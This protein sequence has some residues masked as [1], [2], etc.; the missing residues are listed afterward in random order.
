MISDKSLLKLYDEHDEVDEIYTNLD[1]R[2][3]AVLWLCPAC[4]NILDFSNELETEI[5]LTRSF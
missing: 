5:I 3:I 1:C 2:T 4:P